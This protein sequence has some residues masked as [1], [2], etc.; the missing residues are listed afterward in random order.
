MKQFLLGVML[1]M[2]I[3]ALPYYHYY[4]SQRPPTQTELQQSLND[5]GYD[6]NIDGVVGTNTREAWQEYEQTGVNWRE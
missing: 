6:C 4:K 1:G 2:A 5:W 3:M